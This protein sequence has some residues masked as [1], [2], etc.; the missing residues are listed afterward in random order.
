MA[1]YECA[2][3]KHT[4]TVSIQMGRTSGGHHQCTASIYNDGKLIGTLLAAQLN[5]TVGLPQ[6]RSGNYII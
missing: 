5:N 1:F 3:K 6:T 4:V 2:D